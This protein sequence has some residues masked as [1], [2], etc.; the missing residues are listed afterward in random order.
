MRGGTGVC[1]GGGGVFVCVWVKVSAFS[2]THTPYCGVNKGK[3]ERISE[4]MRWFL[5]VFMFR[6]F[7]SQ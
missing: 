4:L 7:K 6:I 3:N 5:E 1:V 2:H